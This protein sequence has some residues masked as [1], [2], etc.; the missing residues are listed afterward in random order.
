V[1]EV[2]LQSAG[3]AIARRVR[4]SPRP[5]Q[6]AARKIPARRFVSVHAQP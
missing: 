5:A 3:G 2:S 6:N 4:R 1:I